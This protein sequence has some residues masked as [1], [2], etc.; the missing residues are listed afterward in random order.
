[1]R[2]TALGN[3]WR[4]AIMKERPSSIS[5]ALYANG[6][7]GTKVPTGEIFTTTY[8]DVGA[9]PH[10]SRRAP[11][12]TSR[13]RTTAPRS[14]STSTVSQAGQLLTSGPIAVEHGRTPDRRQH[15][16]GRVVP[17]RDR[18]GP[19]LQPRPD[20][21]RD[22]GGHESARHA[23][24]IRVAPSAPGTLT[25][26]GTLSSAQL[27]LGCGDG[28]HRRRPLQRPPRLDAPASR[29]ARPTGSRS[30]PAPATRTPSPRV[31]TTTASP[32]RTA[33]AT[34][35]RRRTRRPRRSAT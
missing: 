3:A 14:R 32:P 30:R 16:L 20:R 9:E 6:S 29:P 23:I 31:P 22:P 27:T 25:A 4:T 33:P 21:H 8:R 35:A 18:R 26:T 28:Q 34:S 24:R 5:Y 2:P 17:G 7:G 19:G 13:R 12:R 1:M 15:D 11:G 10:S